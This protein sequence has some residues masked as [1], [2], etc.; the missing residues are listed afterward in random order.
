MLD[1]KSTLS[2]SDFSTKSRRFVFP[3]KDL[4]LSSLEREGRE[5][6]LFTLEKSRCFT[7]WRTELKKILKLG[8]DHYLFAATVYKG[9]LRR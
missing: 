6:P 2:P 4:V 8:A 7:T 1:T 3:S 9:S 5:K